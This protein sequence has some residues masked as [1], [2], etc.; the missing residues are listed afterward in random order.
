MYGVCSVFPDGVSS[1]IDSHRPSLEHVV[2]RRP[3]ADADGPVGPTG[4]PDAGAKPVLVSSLDICR[5]LLRYLLISD[6]FP[7]TLLSCLFHLACLLLPTSLSFRHLLLSPTIRQSASQ[8]SFS[9]PALSLPSPPLPCSDPIHFAY[10]GTLSF[11]GH[12]V[13]FYQRPRHLSRSLSRLFQ[14]C[15]HPPIFNVHTVFTLRPK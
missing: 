8:T 10:L 9:R 7:T 15:F 4:L 2:C 13:L 5:K 12:C 6:L 14:F 1:L 11:S 3:L